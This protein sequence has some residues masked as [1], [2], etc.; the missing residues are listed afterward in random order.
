MG[1]RFLPF[2]FLEYI[3]RFVNPGKVILSGNF[4]PYDD[5]QL[6]PQA[7]H[8]DGAAQQGLSVLVATQERGT[9][10]RVCFVTFIFYVNF[11]VVMRTY[12]WFL[13][14]RAQVSAFT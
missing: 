14:L 11:A 1:N 4:D 2:L 13:F 8:S 10:A 9:Y 12:Y 7:S 5:I 6:D 3:L